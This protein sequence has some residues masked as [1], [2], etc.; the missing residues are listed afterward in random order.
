MET[1]TVALLWLIVAAFIFWLSWKSH[2]ASSNRKKEAKKKEEELRVAEH[3]AQ[4]QRHFDDM[5]AHVDRPAAL[6]SVDIERL[7][8]I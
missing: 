1:E 3:Y 4:L 8:Q 6:S 5:M 2:E 7:E